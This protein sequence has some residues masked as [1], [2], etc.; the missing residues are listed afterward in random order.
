[1]PWKNPEIQHL[2]ELMTYLC[3]I[4]P[5]LDGQPCPV[6]LW[7]ASVHPEGQ[8]AVNLT[9]GEYQNTLKAR[10]LRPKSPSTKPDSNC[11]TVHHYEWSKLAIF[12]FLLQVIN[13]FL[14]V[15]LCEEHYSSSQ[16]CCSYMNVLGL[17]FFLSFFLHCWYG[18]Q[19][20]GQLMPF[21][22]ECWIL[23]NIIYYV[24][25]DRSLPQ[26]NKLIESSIISAFED[27]WVW[28]NVLLFHLSNCKLINF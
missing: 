18:Q 22:K 26:I 14:V 25:V 9:W 12:D 5:L 27:K 19:C 15:S 3:L 13:R 17:S 2:P 23:L 21:Q 16:F 10:C 7:D 20:S 28:L 4:S 1:M 11:P 24:F 6:V 8:P